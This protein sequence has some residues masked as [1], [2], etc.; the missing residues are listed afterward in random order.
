MGKK[1]IF[2]LLLFLLYL[3]NSHGKQLINKVIVSIDNSIIT[4]LDIN[5]EINYLKFI[6]K[7]Q[8]TNN[9]ELLKKEIIN[10]LIDRKIKDIETNYLK[11]E[12]SEREI[13]NNLYNYLEK[14]KISSENLKTF[15]NKNE[16][17]NDYLK[18]II[19]IDMKWS[20]L[21][22]QIYQSRMDINLTE[23]N[24]QLE[25]EQK[26]SVNEEELKKKLITSEQNKLLNKFSATHLEKSKKKYLIKFL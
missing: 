2:L 8:D 22:R 19:K 3:G 21:V 17:E 25:K 16:I 12:V 11:I 23:V 20:K 7:D 24:I 10:I 18:N 1:K 26:N 13:E 6:N 15:Y 14:M 4:D 5:K 9:L